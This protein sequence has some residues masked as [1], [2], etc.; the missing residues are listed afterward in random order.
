MYFPSK[1]KCFFSTRTYLF[2]HTKSK[3]FKGLPL[4]SRMLWSAWICPYSISYLRVQRFSEKYILMPF[5]TL[6]YKNFEFYWTLTKND[7]K[8]FWG[9]PASCKR[10]QIIW[11]WIRTTFHTINYNNFELFWT[12]WT[13]PQQQQQQ[14]QQEEQ[15]FKWIWNP[16]CAG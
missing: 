3:P 9:M 7:S 5:H 6:N 4:A 8:P 11:T 13:L 1:S 15:D 2:T 12:F 10:L 16:A 14:Q